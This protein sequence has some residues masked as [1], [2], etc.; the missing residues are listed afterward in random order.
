M[1]LNILRIHTE[2]LSKLYDREVK[3]ATLCQLQSL[4]KLL[5]RSGHSL[6]TALVGL[7]SVNIF[8]SK[9]V[10]SADIFTDNPLGKSCCRLACLKVNQ[11]EKVSRLNMIFI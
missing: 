9:I 8:I 3:A 10:C 7:K 11:A 6:N 2:N 1:S 4:V 5:K